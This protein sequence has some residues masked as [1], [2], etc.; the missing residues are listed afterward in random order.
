MPHRAHRNSLGPFGNTGLRPSIPLLLWAAVPGAPN[1]GRR[2]SIAIPREKWFHRPFSPFQARPTSAYPVHY[3]P[4]LASSAI[5]M[6]LLLAPPCGWAGYDPRSPGR[7]RF[8]V[9]H[10]SR[11]DLGPLCTPAVLRVRAGMTLSTRTRLLTFWF[12]PFSTHLAGCLLT[13]L[14]SVQFVLTMSSNSNS[15]PD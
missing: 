1:D 7:Q 15:T 3:K 2:L 14:A 4:A 10:S 11:E 6:L 8:H 13:M 12:Q 9:L 5:P